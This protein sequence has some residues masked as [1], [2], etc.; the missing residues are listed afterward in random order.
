MSVDR[1][2]TNHGQGALRERRGLDD[3][4]QHLSW[5]HRRE[6]VRVAEPDRPSEGPRVIDEAPVP[7]RGVDAALIR[8]MLSVYARTSEPG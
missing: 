4:P 7:D 3:V 2:E 1:V 6:L 8:R 5:T